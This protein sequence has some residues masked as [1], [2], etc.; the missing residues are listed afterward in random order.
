MRSNTVPDKAKLNVK[1]L[2][3]LP[4]IFEGKYNVSNDSV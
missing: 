4:V 1:G 3:T 2:G